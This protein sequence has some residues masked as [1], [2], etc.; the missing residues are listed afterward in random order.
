MFFEIFKK[1]RKKKEKE[2]L[3][4]NKEICVETTNMRILENNSFAF[5]IAKES[6][7]EVE[8]MVN[9]LNFLSHIAQ[10]IS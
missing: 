6:I 1:I 2:I 8:K 9:F 4:E 7:R 3:T 10:Q 5:K